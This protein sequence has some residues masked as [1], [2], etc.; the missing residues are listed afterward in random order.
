MTMKSHMF[1]Y[2]QHFAKWNCVLQYSSM[3][4]TCIDPAVVSTVE[5]Q[6]CTVRISRE[7]II[8]ST[9]NVTLRETDGQ[10]YALLENLL[11]WDWMH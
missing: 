6:K 10:A 2:E 8:Q 4:K 9:R 3:P 11:I 7:C 1:K 5:G